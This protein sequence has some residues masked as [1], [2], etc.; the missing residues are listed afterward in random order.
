MGGGKDKKT[1]ADKVLYDLY[2]LKSEIEIYSE[3][4]CKPIS[5]LYEIYKSID[6]SHEKSAAKRDEEGVIIKKI[7]NLFSQYL[8][9]LNK[10]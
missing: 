4:L 10:N 8:K 7:K 3:D 9:I 2:V 1:E 5:E 6:N